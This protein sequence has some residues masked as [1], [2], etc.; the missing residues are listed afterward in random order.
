[1]NSSDP[2]NAPDQPGRRRLLLR[3]AIAGLVLFVVVFLVDPFLLARVVQLA[4]PLLT[5][6]WRFLLRTIP[7]IHGN[8]DVFLMSGLCV[9]VVLVGAQWFFK[10]LGKSVPLMQ[11]TLPARGW[12]WK[13]TYSGVIALALLF[14]VGMSVG[15]V[16]H[17]LGWFFS[18]PRPMFEARRFGGEDVNNMRQLDGALQ[19]VTLEYRGE[20]AAIRTQL[21]ASEPSYLRSNMSQTL[22]ENYHVLA[23]VDAQGKLAGSL[24]FPREADRRKRAGGLYSFGQED[25]LANE[26]RL[27]EL[28]DRHRPNLISL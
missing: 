26:Q 24:I 16:V 11:A 13:W 25:G 17:Q 1:M 15:G 21:W 4:A 9:V 14:L 18:D 5:G 19:Q 6:W 27:R 20:L 10:W 28:L 23:I 7:A 12:P 8:L 3:I 22:R 2:V